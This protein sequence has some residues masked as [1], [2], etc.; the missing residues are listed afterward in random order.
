MWALKIQLVQELKPN[1]QQERCIFGDWAQCEIVRRCYNLIVSLLDVM[2]REP[3][4]SK[5]E[6]DYNGTTN[7]ECYEA[8]INDFFVS[9]CEDVDIDELLF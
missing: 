5:N 7:G 9:E 4:F 1:N 3:Y 8:M 6:A 2:S